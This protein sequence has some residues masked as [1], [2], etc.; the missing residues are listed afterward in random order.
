MGWLAVPRGRLFG[1]EGP[2]FV[3]FFASLLVDLGGMATVIMSQ[4]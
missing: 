3:R 4:K 2:A 1:P